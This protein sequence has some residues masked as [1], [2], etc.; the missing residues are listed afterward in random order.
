MRR[1]L[2]SACM[3]LAGLPAAASSIDFDAGLPN[4][5]YLNQHAYAV[6]GTCSD[7]GAVVDVAIWPLTQQAGCTASGWS[8][9]FDAS[10]L[11]D[12]STV[13][14]ATL[15]TAGGTYLAGRNAGTW[16][17]TWIDATLGAYSY[18]GSPYPLDPVNNS[19]QARYGVL[20]AGT[21]LS[22]VPVAILFFIL[23]R[24]FIAGLAS[25]AVKG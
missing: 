2:A 15:M 16:K 1:L 18:D 13:M 25:G 23:Q 19:N 12:G 24:D 9:T 21:L 17:D 4:I 5:D 10:S 22:I 6:H 14:S 8:A 7:V 3:G 20:M 11:P